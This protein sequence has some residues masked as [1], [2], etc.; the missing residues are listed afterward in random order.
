MPDQAKPASPRGDKP[1]RPAADR[2]PL[3]WGQTT[4]EFLYRLRGQAIRLVTLD[5]KEY[6]GQLVGVDR[7]E[8]FLQPASGP[9]LCMHKHAIKYI[10]ADAAPANGAN[11]KAAP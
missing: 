8:V 4:A 10:S 3:Y 9:V 11:G 7:F 5:G 1:A 2:P 6:R